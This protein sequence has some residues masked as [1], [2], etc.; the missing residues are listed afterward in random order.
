V[1]W[2]AAGG[3]VD[4]AGKS[5]EAWRKAGQD[6]HS[7][8]ADP[9]FADPEHGDFALAPGSPALKQGFQPIDT[10]QVGPRKGLA[11]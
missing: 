1:Y 2:N 10:S 9:L 7:V 6:A 5:L 8:V 11:R 4:F 3:K